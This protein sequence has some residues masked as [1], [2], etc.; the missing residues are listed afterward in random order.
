MV[1]AEKEVVSLRNKRRTEVDRSLN[2]EKTHMARRIQKWYR[3]L[4]FFTYVTASPSANA[5]KRTLLWV[6]KEEEW[7]AGPCSKIQ[8]WYR[9]IRA[10]SFTVR[11][12]TWFRCIQAKALLTHLKSV[13]A[14][15]LENLLHDG[16]FPEV[17]AT[18]S[19]QTWFR[20]LRAKAHLS[21]LKSIHAVY[22]EKMLRSDVPRDLT[23]CVKIQT[24]FRCLRAKALL[25][26]LK[27]IHAVY[28]ERTLRDGV[29]IVDF[30]S[31]V[32]IQAMF[33]KYRE[34]KRLHHLKVA[35]AA[36]K[37]QTW[38]RCITATI[39]VNN[40]TTA[41]H[42]ITDK[43][44]QKENREDAACV[45][46]QRCI[47]KAL[48][49][50][51]KENMLTQIQQNHTARTLGEKHAKSLWEVK[52]ARKTVSE[53]QEKILEMLIHNDK[54][55][56]AIKIQSAA[57]MNAAKRL[58]G[59]WRYASQTQE[60]AEFIDETDYFEKHRSVQT[61]QLWWRVSTANAIARIKKSALTETIELREA[62]EREYLRSNA[63]VVQAFSRAF[64]SAAK[65]ARKIIQIR[66]FSQRSPTERA[67]AARLIQSRVRIFFARTAMCSMVQR[68]N[69][70]Q[71][72]RI[73]TDLAT[74]R[75][76]MSVMA[77]ACITIQSVYRGLIQRRLTRPLRR[78]RFTESLEIC[79]QN[80]MWCHDHSIT[81]EKVITIQRN[82]R[83]YIAVKKVDSLR[84][85]FF[86]TN[87]N[88]VMRERAWAAHAIQLK[89]KPWISWKR[90]A[91]VPALKIQAWY[92]VKRRQQ[93]KRRERASRIITGFM[94]KAT[95]L[96]VRIRA[97]SV[98]QTQYRIV[99]RRRRAM[100]AIG[101]WLDCMMLLQNAAA[102]RLQRTWWYW[103]QAIKQDS[104]RAGVEYQW[105]KGFASIAL[106]ERAELPPS[107]PDVDLPDLLLNG[108]LKRVAKL[109]KDEESHRKILL[110]LHTQGIT[111]KENIFSR[112][113]IRKNMKRRPNCPYTRMRAEAFKSCTNRHTVGQFANNTIDVMLWHCH[114]IPVRPPEKLP[115]NKA[116]VRPPGKRPSTAFVRRAIST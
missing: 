8:A 81:T 68:R 79:E 19:I 73:K 61:I 25:S 84:K 69:A 42:I 52:K 90:P 98:I 96:Q 6:T 64:A 17:R 72:E 70:Y 28:L 56:A 110:Q 66:A 106:Q 33:R 49:A 45:T 108:Y 50:M 103:K 93:S 7:M 111:K 78:R 39:T 107:L 5:A 101:S 87:F 57:R 48:A 46:M 9:G 102:V 18:I 67:H 113:R 55:T 4:R 83:Q 109:W 62:A 34:K 58:V 100:A 12:Q 59:T 16:V 10:K 38:F 14:A 2:V 94:R 65:T 47:K 27:S 24:W 3:T 26:R 114:K 82:W 63:V 89:W 37:I 115:C 104:S 15:Y 74:D 13:H 1:L 20:C 86:E 40:I 29:P 76:L 92:R 85:E 71:N 31:T 75:K 99:I 41:N 22:L 53:K 35:R 95:Y 32:M 116:P 91:Q 80:L 36:V 112:L 44:V 21:R 11:I 30:R 88:A 97:V 23:A 54:T 105:A 77:K 43:R 60:V 51:V